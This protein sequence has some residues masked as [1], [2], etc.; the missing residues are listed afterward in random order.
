MFEGFLV[1]FVAALP[2]SVILIYNRDKYDLPRVVN[3]LAMIV[4]LA[5]VAAGVGIIGTV[6]G[7][8]T[9]SFTFN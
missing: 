6:M 4:L 3:I 8:A 1:L 5:S 7:L 9:G 2:L